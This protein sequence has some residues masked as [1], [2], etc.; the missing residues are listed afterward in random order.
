MIR[1]PN[2]AVTIAF[3]HKHLS[4][5]YIVRLGISGS[6]TPNIENRF[7]NI[8]CLKLF[9]ASQSKFYQGNDLFNIHGTKTHFML[10][11]IHSIPRNDKFM[12]QKQKQRHR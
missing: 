8:L 2:R 10:E 12:A 5:H 1:L 11:I 6:N 3:Y 7:Q 9:I 4:C